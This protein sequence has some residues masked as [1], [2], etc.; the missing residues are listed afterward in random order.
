MATPLRPS[1]QASAPPMTRIGTQ[2]PPSRFLDQD[3]RPRRPP[4]HR[5]G[6]AP[7]RQSLPPAPRRPRP[8]PC[9]PLPRRPLRPRTRP[10]R[11]SRRHRPPRR[12]RRPHAPRR[13]LARRLRPARLTQSNPAS[14]SASCA[15]KAASTPE[16]L[17]RSGARGLMQ[18]MPATAAEV[19]GKLGLPDQHGRPSPPTRPTT[20]ASARPI[21][22]ALL[23]RFG[24][25][26][27]LAIAAYN[28]GPNRVADWLIGAT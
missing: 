12:R 22:P 23:A 15:R 21:S 10:P 14:P 1:P 20:C 27:P 17:S 11:T 24:G 13:R 2:R 18:L 4:P 19:A 5:L 8:Q 3:N 9:R 7:P 26:L 16:A 28:A 25:A 6:R